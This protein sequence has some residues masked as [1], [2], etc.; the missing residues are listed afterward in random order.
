MTPTLVMQSAVLTWMLAAL[1]AAA[2]PLPAAPLWTRPPSLDLGHLGA[3]VRLNLP[4]DLGGVEADPSVW[5][6]DAALAR[7]VAAL[8]AVVD[9][10]NTEIEWL[11]ASALLWLDAGDFGIDTALAELTV[12]GYDREAC[13]NLVGAVID[14]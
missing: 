13:P 2:P 9:T 4:V 3:S 8:D 11:F 14:V 1:V 12:E 6:L 10:F 5:A 7:D